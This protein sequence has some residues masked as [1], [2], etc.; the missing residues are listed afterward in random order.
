MR[1]DLDFASTLARSAGAIVRE[2]V[3]RAERLTKLHDEAVTA[4]DRASQRHIV[5]ALSARFPNDGILGEENDAGTGITFTQPRVG[6]RVWVID[7]IDGTNNFVAG[8]G[9]FAVCIG[10]LDNGFPVLGVVYDVMRDQLFAAAHGLGAQCNGRAISALTSAP[11]ASSLLML[12]SN[13]L[14]AQGRMPTWAAALH[15]QTH[16]K[17][18]VLGSAA[19]EAVMVAAGIAHAS[20]T[21]NGKLWDIAAAAAIILQAGGKITDL[22]GKPLFPLAL[23]GYSGAKIP[24]LAA[25]P[26]AGDVF[27]QHLAKA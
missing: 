1:D 25:A 20:I 4:V 12:T 21:V 16:W 19:L 8:L 27:L 2:Q 26:G 6:T 3:G 14:N 22:V 11:D 10:L 15:A 13:L 7:P 17:V 9:N 23:H 18:R 5:S 24:Y